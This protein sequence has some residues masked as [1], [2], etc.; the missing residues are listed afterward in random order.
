MS[1]IDRLT[2]THLDLDVELTNFRKLLGDLSD[3]GER[4]EALYELQQTLELVRKRLERHIVSENRLEE[5]S[6]AV[7][8]EGSMSEYG[9]QEHQS[10]LRK[11][12][13]R[14]HTLLHSDEAD[15][16]V[17]RQFAKVL[18]HFELYTAAEIEF[19]QSNTA[20]LYPG[21]NIE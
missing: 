2:R 3:A 15:E 17:H 1:L 9:V 5:R 21:G 7:L 10:K 4:S 14:L 18:H 13:D 20:V 12:I 6:D 19:L 11:V 16:A 8:G